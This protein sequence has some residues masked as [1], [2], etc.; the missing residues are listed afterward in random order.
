MVSLLAAVRV[1]ARWLQIEPAEAGAR[2]EQL[3]ELDAVCVRMTS[4]RAVL[5]GCDL[6]PLVGEPGVGLSQLRADFAAGWRTDYA[7]VRVA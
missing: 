1:A 6:R 3:P 4:G 7:G 5:V 2:A